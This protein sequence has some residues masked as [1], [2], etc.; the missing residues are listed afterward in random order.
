[1]AFLRAGWGSP[2]RRE[3]IPARLARLEAGLGDLPFQGEVE[4]A[5]RDAIT[6]SVEKRWRRWR[7]MRL[8]WCSQTRMSSKG[9]RWISFAGVDIGRCRSAGAADLKFL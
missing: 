9:N 5:A 2:P 8:S 3:L 1:M 7:Q 6:S 4:P